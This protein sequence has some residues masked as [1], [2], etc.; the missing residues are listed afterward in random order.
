MFTTL[1]PGSVRSRRRRLP[2]RLPSTPPIM[3]SDM[4]S[5][6]TTMFTLLGALVVL[7][8]MLTTFHVHAGD[9]MASDL[10]RSE[11]A[12]CGTQSPCHVTSGCMSRCSTVGGG[13]ETPAA[14]DVQRSGPLSVKPSAS[15]PSLPVHKPPPRSA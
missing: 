9:G 6:S 10:D 3:G 13:P 2:L 15:P 5:R 8:A 7:L 4:L 1:E 11:G 14:L 12:N